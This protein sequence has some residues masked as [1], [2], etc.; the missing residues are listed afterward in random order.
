MA[1]A[2]KF[3]AADYLD[4]KEAI[5]DYLSEAFATG[6]SNLITKAIGTVAR[7]KGM[8]AVAKEAGQ[9]RENL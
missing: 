3:D 6:D 1:K 4:S 2:S 5:A 9:N 7:V 8:G